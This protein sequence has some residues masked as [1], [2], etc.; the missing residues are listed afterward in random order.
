[1]RILELRVDSTSTFEEVDKFNRKPLVTGLTRLVKEFS[2][3][4]VICLDGK[5]G[6]G[7]TVFLQ[8]WRNDLNN[9]GFP[10]L[11]LNAFEKDFRGDAFTTVCAA[12]LESHGR[13]GGDPSVRERFLHKAVQVAKGFGFLALRVGLRAATAGVIELRDGDVAADEAVRAT[14]EF[15]DRS[16]VSAIESGAEQERAVAE[17]K[18]VLEQIALEFCRERGGELLPAVFIVDELDRCRPNFAVEM[19]EVLKHFFS[20][21]N[22]VF[23]LGANLEILSK[24]VE[25]VYGISGEGNHYLRR[26]MN[27]VVRFSGRSGARRRAELENFLNGLW[28]RGGIPE[29]HREIR[30]YMIELLVDIAVLKEVSLRDLERIMG[31]LCVSLHFISRGNIMPP[32]LLSTLVV[33]RV[34]EPGLF[35]KACNGSLSFVELDSWFNFDRIEEGSHGINWAR[36]WLH[37]LMTSPDQRTED[38]KNILK[39]VHIHGDRPERFVQFFAQSIVDAAWVS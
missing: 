18:E 35:E 1:M 29:H 26:F 12:I 23:V 5:W 28:D 11:Y 2:G 4:T 17:F 20:A 24:S 9:N 39:S 15:L 30:N 19:L 7:K 38:Q 21:K 8:L 36:R 31:Q 13:L 25:S 10:T 16:L 33:L 27:I 14:S 22:V 6:E 3:E 32:P 34:L 37:A